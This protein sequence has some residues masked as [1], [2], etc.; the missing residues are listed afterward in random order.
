[1]DEEALWKRFTESGSTADYLAYAAVRNNPEKDL[2]DDNG[3]GN[4]PE[5]TFCG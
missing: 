4:C 1:M 2:T 5:G 3:R